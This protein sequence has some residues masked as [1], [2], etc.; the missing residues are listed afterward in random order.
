[1]KGVGTNEDQLIRIICGGDIPERRQIKE[2]FL[3]IY[4][5]ELIAWVESET[6]GNFKK[7]LSCLL[8][9]KESEFDL[10]ADCQAM[11][12][13]MDGWGTDE[14]ALINLICSKT[15]RQ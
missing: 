13:A 14:T 7:A 5:T 8:N 9:A 11:K 3:R 4:Q 1:M 12:A 6:S 2:A 10:E 15:S